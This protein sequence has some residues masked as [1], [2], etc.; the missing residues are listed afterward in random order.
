[1]SVD[2][3]AGDTVNVHYKIKEGEKTRI[4][5]YQGIVISSRGAGF[6]KTFTVRRLGADGIGVE[7][8]FQFNSP[9]IEKIDVVKKGK[10]RRAK[11]YYLRDKIGA[12][13]YRIKE[14]ASPK[15]AK[16]EQSTNWLSIINRARK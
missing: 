3:K 13:A 11:L 4:Q 6:S 5:P 8:I 10:V 7:R 2:F 12:A 1:M 9:N 15:A 16:N 14:K